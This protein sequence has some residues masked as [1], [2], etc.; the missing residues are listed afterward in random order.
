MF[1]A[2]S[3]MGFSRRCRQMSEYGGIMA[4]RRIERRLRSKSE[5][6]IRRQLGLV[7]VPANFGSLTKSPCGHKT[8]RGGVQLLRDPF[9]FRR[10]QRAS[11]RGEPGA[12][13]RR[14]RRSHAGGHDSMAW[15][16][17]PEADVARSRSSGCENSRGELR[18]PRRSGRPD[19][20]LVKKGGSRRTCRPTGGRF[21]DH[22]PKTGSGPSIP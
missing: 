16:H 9:C 11:N 1:H 6:D 5:Q 2:A 10:L 7:G 4:N 8:N 21:R 12:I 22:C 14:G 19:H 20:A 18:R 15:S 17:L 3:K 13:L